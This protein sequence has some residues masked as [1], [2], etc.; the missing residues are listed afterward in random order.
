MSSS[1]FAPLLEPGDLAAKSTTP[2]SGA[3]VAAPVAALPMRF[4]IDD[5]LS[6]LVPNGTLL[7][8]SALG[9][10]T[11]ALAERRDL[12]S[13]LVVEDVE[14]RWHLKLHQSLFFDVWLLGW[15]AN[16]ETDWH[17]HG[18][19]AGSFAVAEG[20]LLEQF[21]RSGN[22]RLAARE[23]TGGGSTSFGP[24]HVH[25]VRHS[26]TGASLSIHAYSPPLVAMTYY[27]LGAFG[28]TA[29]ETLAVDSPEGA[30]TRSPA[31]QASRSGTAGDVRSIRDLLDEVRH[32]LDRVGPE[33][34]AVEIAAGA[35]LV[36]I[37]PP[38]Q[39][40]VEGEVPGAFV[41]G[42]NVLEWRLDPKSDASIPD[43]ARYDRRIIVM[44]SEGYASSLAAA[45]LRQLG[46]SLATDL[47]GG[48]Q[49]WKAAGLPTRELD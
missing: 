10:I 17:D 23:L 22:R 36:D 12:W 18:G 24:T 33:V 19:S 46:L 44:C 31:R 15:Q 49:A 7:A 25:N 48:F 41:I 30:R 37:R 16:Q 6:R 28:L 14:Q 1:P 5:V 27:E 47:D 4:A 21:R 29:K 20:G 9:R 40:L 13:A 34:A 26:G 8:P 43:L 3:R 2:A 39:R 32:G 38:E 42:R 45:T 11:A 35:A